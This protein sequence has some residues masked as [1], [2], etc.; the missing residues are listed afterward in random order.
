MIKNILPSILAA[1][2]SDFDTK[3]IRKA[4]QSFVPSPELTPGRMNIFKIKNFE[5]MIDYVHNTDGFKELK[6]FMQKMHASIKTG[7]I[8]CAGDRR[9]N[10][11]RLMGR[12]AAETF[13]EIIIRHDEDGRGRTN[14]ELTQLISEGI[15]SVDSTMEIKVISDELEALD[16][17]MQNAVKGS[18]IVC[19]SDK[20]QKSI[21]FLSKIKQEEEEFVMH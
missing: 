20:V 21:E 11:I 7:I 5:V 2:I 1:A 10:D 18:F 17:A 12:Y 16:Y 15:Y 14:E 6:S 3:I 19:C 4:L 8:G 9:D 13:D